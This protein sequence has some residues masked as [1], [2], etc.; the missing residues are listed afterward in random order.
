MK[1]KLNWGTLSRI[2]NT[3][4][5]DRTNI[6]KFLSQ[7]TVDLVNTHLESQLDKLISSKLSSKTAEPINFENI[8]FEDPTSN[9]NIVFGYNVYKDLVYLSIL[10]ESALDILDIRDYGKEKITKITMKY[11]SLTL[12]D[13]GDGTYNYRKEGRGGI[14]LLDK[15]GMK[16]AEPIKPAGIVLSV[17][18]SFVD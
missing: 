5:L 13:N 17:G 11:K 1:N 18:P 9:L 4:L 6:S 14:K 15:H 3:N 10:D 2:L 8:R 7:E 12:H 16:K